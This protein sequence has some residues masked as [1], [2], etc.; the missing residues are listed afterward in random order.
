MHMNSVSQVT[1]CGQVLKQ[2][3]TYTFNRMPNGQTQCIVRLGPKFKGVSQHLDKKFAKMQACENMLKII[4]IEHPDWKEDQAKNKKARKK[5]YKYGYRIRKEEESLKKEI[6]Q[7]EARRLNEKE[8]EKE[9]GR[10]ERRSPGR[11]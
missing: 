2:Q 5:T 3:T 10:S 7:T 4:E 6:E 9:K 8:R 1:Q 11:R